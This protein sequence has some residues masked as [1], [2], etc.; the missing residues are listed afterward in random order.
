MV[1]PVTQLDAQSGQLGAVP[2]GR[3]RCAEQGAGAP[4][5]SDYATGIMQPK[6]DRFMSVGTVASHH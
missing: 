5:R 4:S 1:E 3:L 2:G 6:G